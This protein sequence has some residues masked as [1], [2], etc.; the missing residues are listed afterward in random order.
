MDSFIQSTTQEL[1]KSVPNLLGAVAILILGWLF[2][3]IV[4]W[5]VKA[6][7]SRTNLDNRLAAAMT[8]GSDAKP[9]ANLEQWLAAAVFWIIMLFV[10]VAFLQA[11]QLQVVSG[12]LN[13]LL[14]QIFVYL[15]KVAG[16]A[17]LLGVAWLLA[18]FCRLIFVRGL[19]SFSLD[20]R[21][22]AQSAGAETDGNPPVVLSETLGNALYW[23]IFLLFLPG[24]LDALNLQ[25]PLQPVQSL[26]NEIL[27]ILPNV[28]GAIFI[29]AAGWFVA[30][31]VR[32]IVTNLLSA[33]GADQAGE[34]FGLSRAT[35]GQGLSSLTGTVVYVLILIP[36]AI[37]AFNALEIRAISEPA[38]AMLSD[39][40][41]AIPKI[42][43]AAIILLVGYVL[44]KIIGELV[45]NLL[46]GIGFNNVFSWLGLQAAQEPI[47]TMP[48]GSSSDSPATT[49]D[50]I[51]RKTPSEIAGVVVLVGI[52][53]VF[54]IP[55]TDVLQFQPLTALM[56]EL[57]RLLG[58]VLVGVL[59]FAVGLYLANLVFNILSSSGGSQA[60]LVA[61]AA[62]IAIIALVAAMALQQMG[63]ATSIVNLAFGLLFGAVAVALAVA[64]GFGSMGVAEEQVRKWLNE[65]QAKD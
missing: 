35:G 47:D 16:A 3:I 41:S 11:L 59:V 23:F 65:F 5:M 62:R 51:A 60:K 12:P 27:S 37:A 40:L 6:V 63:I 56:T 21:L 18:T 10:L 13:D 44:G 64:F 4:S 7:L 49:A 58:Q 26:V 54:L 17:V 1:S 15:P 46:T 8:G 14:S 24:I 25:G 31:I 38:I 20:D 43:T 45:T 19:Q 9:I 2:A 39:I 34:R 61:Q 28:L 53:L 22:N 55:A 30:R 36:V 29:G 32:M 42:F 52:I 48:S 57:L 33:A 50:A